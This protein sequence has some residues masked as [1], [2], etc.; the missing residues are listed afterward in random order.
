MCD[1]FKLVRWNDE[2][3]KEINLSIAWCN[4][5]KHFKW[6]DGEYNYITTKAQAHSKTTQF[7]FDTEKN[8]ERE[9]KLAAN[10]L[11]AQTIA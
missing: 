11:F 1:Q 6:I 9:R 4:T 5:Q 10:I 7:Y 2:I 8:D 3:Q